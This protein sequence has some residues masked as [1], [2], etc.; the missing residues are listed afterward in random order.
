MGNKVIRM[1]ATSGNEVGSKIDY[2]VYIFFL[3]GQSVS[4]YH[5]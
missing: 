2:W 5:L 1:I 3:I 4:F